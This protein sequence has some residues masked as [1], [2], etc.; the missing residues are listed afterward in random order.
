MSNTPVLIFYCCITNHPK[1]RHSK[2]YRFI[3]S[4]N[5][6]GQELGQGSGG[7][8]FCSTGHRQGPLGR[9]A[10]AGGGLDV[11]DVSGPWMLFYVLCVCVCVCV[12]M[13]DGVACPHSVN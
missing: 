5:S 8:L 13:H 4:H 10:V 3:I 12:C 2:Q 11:T 7:R 6:V 9:L 1:T